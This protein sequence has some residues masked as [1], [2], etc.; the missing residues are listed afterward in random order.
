MLGFLIPQWVVKLIVAVF[1]QL[2]ISLALFSLA[3]LVRFYIAIGET[4]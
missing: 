4:A 3:R 2:A 1:R